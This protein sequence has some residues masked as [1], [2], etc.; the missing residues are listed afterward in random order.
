MAS[1]IKDSISS[2]SA[3][4]RDYRGQPLE[5]D[6]IEVATCHEDFAS[7]YGN[8]FGE[9]A[10]GFNAFIGSF[11]EDYTNLSDSSATSLDVWVSLAR[12]QATVVKNLVDNK[13][14]SNPDY[15]GTQASVN[16]VQGSVLEAT[17]A[18]KG[19]EIALFIGGDFPIQ[20][21]ARGLLVDMTQFLSLIH[22]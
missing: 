21:A 18:G 8:F 11:F 6:Y 1:S 3:W 13:F 2:I 7:P 5:L 10:F 4:M 12:D 19:P 15:N 16:L 9:L 20:L 22:I 17:L 14:N